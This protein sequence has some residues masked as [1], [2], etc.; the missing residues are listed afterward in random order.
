MT[1]ART[2]FADHL[3]ELP[4]VVILRGL[5]PDAAVSLAQEAWSHGVSLVEVTLQDA[6]GYAALEAVAS[7]APAG[8]DVGAGTITEASQVQLALNAGAR[9]GI[10]PGFDAA[11]VREAERLGVPFLPGVATASEVQAAQASGVAAAKAFPADVLTPSW[12]TA[13]RGPFPGMGFIAT[14]GVSAENAQRFLDAGALG[15]AI[16][17]QPGSSRLREVSAALKG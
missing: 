1:D 15:V 12:I 6:G 13:M 17:L 9:F 7:A 10:A 16:S 14:G 5:E 2:Y 3:R 11:S 8:Y 4:I